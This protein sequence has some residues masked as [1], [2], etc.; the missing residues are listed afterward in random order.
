MKQITAA[1][2]LNRAASYCTLCERC[3][4]E[5]SNKLTAWG[6]EIKVQQDI[7]KRLINEN[8]INEERYSKAFVNDKIRFNHWGRKKISAALYEKRISKSIIGKAIAT[9]DEEEYNEILHKVL[10]AKHKELKYRE[11]NSTRQ[12]LLRF[13]ASRGFETQL[14]IKALKIS[15]DEMDF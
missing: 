9:I 8:F 6:V 10:S 12:K 1:E 15:N 14:I 4:S 3:I 5:V 11:D 2:A 7:I 13:A